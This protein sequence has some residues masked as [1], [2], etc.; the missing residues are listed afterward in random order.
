MKKHTT[1]ISVV[2]I[3]IIIIVSV[4]AYSG[5]GHGSILKNAIVKVD[6]SDIAIRVFLEEMIPH[7]Q[8]AV[9]TSRLVMNDLDITNP[10]IRGL[11]ARIDDK[12]TFEVL[13]MDGWY[14]DWFGEYFDENKTLLRVPYEPMMGDLTVLKGDALAKAYLTGMIEHHEHAIMTSSEI[15]DFITKKEQDNTATDGQITVV[16][17]VPAIDNTLILIKDIQT[18]QAKE[19]QEMKV[20]LE[21][22]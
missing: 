21:T 6:N 12:Q 8:E 5:M 17:S 19:I 7:H 20:L 1:I 13:K 18:D 15:K 16:N 14:F 22:L 3:L 10:E 2:S 11:A 4:F 9:R